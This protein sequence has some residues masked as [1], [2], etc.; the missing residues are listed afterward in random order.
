MQG[1]RR[2]RSAMV[3]E[4]LVHGESGFPP[5]LTLL[6]ALVLLAIGVLAIASMVF[7]IGPFG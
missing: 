2:Q 4:G 6:T 7:R 5:S 3:A 1:L